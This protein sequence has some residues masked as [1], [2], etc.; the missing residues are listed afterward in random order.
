MSAVPRLAPPIAPR[1]QPAPAVPPAPAA[2]PA[3]PVTLSTPPST[4]ATVTLSVTLG[5]HSERGRKA[6]NQDFHGACV[7]SPPLLGSKGIVL[8]LADGIGSSEVSHEAS[9]AAV[10]SA[11]EDY[12]GTSD[13]WSVKRSMSRVL[14]ATNSWLHAQTRRGPHRYEQDRGHVCAMSVLVLKGRTAHVFHVG[15]TRVW[16][17]QGRTLEPL[18][19]DHRVYVGGGQSHLSRAMGF[20][21]R[22]ELDYQSWP[23]QVGDLFVLACDGVHEHVDSASLAGLVQAHGDDLDGAARAIVAQALERGSPDNLTVQLLRVDGLPDAD[24]SELQRQ[25]AGLEPPPLLAPRTEIDGYRIERE[26]HAS[27][28]SHLYLATD[29]ASGDAVVLKAPSIDLGQDT[30]HLDRLLMEEWVARR[31][32]NAHLVK[33]H[34]A[35][36]E[37]S[38]LYVVMEHLTGCTLAQWRR[39]H[40]APDLDTVRRIVEQIARGLQALHRLEV[41]HQDL[42]PENVMIDAHGTVKIIDFGSARVAGLVESGPPPDRES[43]PGTLAFM[44]PEYFLGEVGSEQSDQYALGVIAYHLLTGRLPYGTRVAGLRTRA[45]L[46]RLRYASARDG[47]DRIPDWVDAALMKAVHPQ[48]HRR[49]EA[50]SAF[51]QALSHPDPAL[52]GLARAALAER[53]PV[54]FWQGVS[55]LLALLVLALA[56]ALHAARTS[57]AASPPNPLASKVSL[58]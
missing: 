25:R 34:G 42:R 23:V 18:T 12:Y 50:L 3:R 30:E 37:R 39:D 22:I 13:A 10:R 58:R 17:L 38:R 36:R 26:L 20:H 5:Q 9:Q 2:A 44:A 53:H 16:R 35:R 41:L 45:D 57:P 1:A 52:P 48:P 51:V 8:A 31:L 24:P 15:D 33:A 43:P 6:V 54:R 49:H 14:A 7:P 47:C 56:G 11:L 32:D 46:G 28:R 40:P 4:T 21:A 55:L 19:E 27:S 29:L